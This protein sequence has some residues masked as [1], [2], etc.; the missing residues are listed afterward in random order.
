MSNSSMISSPLSDYVCG[1][2]DMYMASADAVGLECFIIIFV[3]SLNKMPTLILFRMYP[4]P[5]LEV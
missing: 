4:I 1:L 5:Y 3:L 2:L